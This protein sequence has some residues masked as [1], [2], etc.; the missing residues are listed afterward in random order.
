MKY[1][2][3]LRF[4]LNSLKNASRIYNILNDRKFKNN[5]LLGEILRN[6]HSIEKGLSLENVRLGF[7]VKKK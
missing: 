3:K 2:T 4:L 7:G 6:T 1:L 5:R